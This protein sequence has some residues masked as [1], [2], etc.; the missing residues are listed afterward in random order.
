M[1]KIYL[2]SVLTVLLEHFFIVQLHAQWT[3]TFLPQARSEVA[4]SSVGS[5][6]LFAGGQSSTSYGTPYQTDRVDVYDA[7]TNQWSVST[8]S[9]PRSRIAAATV[10]DLVFFAGGMTR[11]FGPSHSWATVDIYTESTNQWTTAQLSQARH[12]I[13]AVSAGG[14]V[15][16]A[17]GSSLTPQDVLIDYSAVDIYDVA[18]KQ[19]SVTQLP[20]LKG[21]NLGA[22]SVG[23][24]VFF[25][26]DGLL[27]IYDIA[28][29]QW[30][31]STIPRVKEEVVAV[32]VGNKVLLAG[33]SPISDI[34]DI[35]DI[36]T[37]Q[38][39]MAQLSQARS[40]VSAVS[41]DNKVFFAGGLTAQSNDYSNVLDVY[42][43][44]TNQLVASQLPKVKGNLATV[45]VNNQ[46]LL[47]ENNQVTT[48]YSQPANVDIFT[49]NL[50]LP[51]TL[52]SFAG[53]WID[54]VGTQLTWQTSFETN[55]DY[56]EIQRS[57]N[58]KVYETIGRIK[59]QGTAR[60]LNEYSFV[61][62]NKPDIINYY[63]L[64][65][66]D[67]DG[68]VHFSKIISVNS[69]E[70]YQQSASLS[71][72]PIPATE[73]LT[74]SL[75]SGQ[76]ISEMTIYSIHGQRMV[77]SIKPQ[78]KVDVSGLTAGVY[79]IDILTSDNK[80]LRSRFVKQQ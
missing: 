4:A 50:A 76:T 19:W 80:H 9:I 38:W 29:G 14:K 10:S 74:I 57:S 58:A 60:T 61:D 27:D 78:Q 13:A 52:V 67:F 37:N 72:W 43:V 21:S 53:V 23:N 34:V 7:L 36:S 62:T 31:I 26:G 18:T 71:V 51:V 35:Y 5:K 17:G 33:G 49:V 11:G 45:R 3:S 2:I 73:S 46:I 66:V 68:K 55:N 69:Q 47:A 8:L 28:T 59:G 65:Q 16:F 32:S 42:D 12:S 25:A 24:K 40:K 44:N 20:R 1:K 48:T 22:T 30:T 6:A 70:G 79:L 56:F 64:K 75:S 41:I 63:R 77:S 39:T 15:L 54:E